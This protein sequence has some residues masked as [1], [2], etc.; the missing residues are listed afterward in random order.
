ML[1]K[2][3]YMWHFFVVNIFVIIS[4][5]FHRY[6][7]VS[8]CK[9]T[10]IRVLVATIAILKL[11]CHCGP[12][13]YQYQGQNVTQLTHF[14]PIIAHSYWFLL[15]KVKAMCGR[16][17]LLIFLKLRL[18]FTSVCTLQRIGKQEKLKPLNS[19]KH[20][21]STAQNLHKFYGAVDF[22]IINFAN[23]TI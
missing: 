8:K 11:V 4:P 14:P 15:F 17:R 12:L 7:A 5:Y 23:C 9:A 3:L 1:I 10:V 13:A 2:G 16:G 21:S 20:N 22:R 18:L 19:V 6:S